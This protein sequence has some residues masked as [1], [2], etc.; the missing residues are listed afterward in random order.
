VCV[1][2]GYPVALHIATSYQH[3]EVAVHGFDHHRLLKAFVD[4]IAQLGGR[5]GLPGVRERT[6]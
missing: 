4:M 5:H 1:T 6:E 3:S 2:S